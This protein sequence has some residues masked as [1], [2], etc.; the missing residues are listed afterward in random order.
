MK[1]LKNGKAMYIDDVPNEALKAE[2]DDLKRPIRHL[3]NTVY[4]KSVFLDMWCGFII[5][6]IHKKNERLDVNNHWCIIIP[7][8]LG[9]LSLPIINKRIK[10]CMLNSNK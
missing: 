4:K 8:C 6:P 1:N 7:S 9:K 2:S 10:E 3:F 5:V